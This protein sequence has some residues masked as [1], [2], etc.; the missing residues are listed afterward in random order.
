[1]LSKGFNISTPFN[2]DFLEKLTKRLGAL[3]ISDSVKVINE[4]SDIK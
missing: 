1:M 3:K 4:E 2:E